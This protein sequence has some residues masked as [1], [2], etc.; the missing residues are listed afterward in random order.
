MNHELNMT[1]RSAKYGV[2]CALVAT[3]LTAVADA[4]LPKGWFRN[5]W[6]GYEP[7]A[8]METTDGPL[9]G[10]W[11]I[12]VSDIASQHGFGIL[13][14]RKYPAVEGDRL[15]VTFYGKGK[16]EAKISYVSFTAE[17]KWNQPR[18][19]RGFE[20]TDEWRLYE[21]EFVVSDKTS[22]EKTGFVQPS[23]HGTKDSECWFSDVRADVTRS[24]IDPVDFP[25]TRE[26]ADR[27]TAFKD[28]FE[29]GAKDGEI[30]T[31]DIAPGLLSKTQVGVYRTDGA[32]TLPYAAKASVP[33]ADDVALSVGSRLY[34]LKGVYTTHVRVGGRDLSLELK[35]VKPTK[36]IEGRLLDAGR[37]VGSFRMPRRVLPAD[38]RIDLNASGGWGVDVASLSD[39][40]LRHYLGRLNAAPTGPAAIAWEIVAEPGSN[41]G[42]AV[43]NLEV[44]SSRVIAKSSAVPYV[45]ERLATF[46]P[47]K[48]GWPL[49]FEDEFEGNEVDWS[50]WYFPHYAGQHKDCVHTDG[51]G[52]LVVEA[53]DDGTGKIVTDGIWSTTALEYGYF[54]ARLKFTK[55]PGWWAAFWLYGGINTNPFIDGFEIDIF[56]DYYT[57]PREGDSRFTG[58]LDHNNHVT[59]GANTKS[60]NFTTKVPG[61]F[62]DWH[63]IACKWTPFEIS[64]YMD[65]KLMGAKAGHG[66]YD[67]VTFDAIHHFAGITP[68]HAIC[69]GQV[70]RREKKN[71]ANFPERYLIDRV[72][73]YA[74]PQPKDEF[75]SVRWTRGPA[76]RAIVPEGSMLAFSVDA[77]AKQG[78]KVSGVYLFDNGYLIDYKAKPPYDFNV[79]FSGAAYE[80]TNYMKPGRSGVKPKF[81]GYTHVF[82]A[83]VQDESGRTSHTEPIWRIPAKVTE[84]PYEGAAQKIPGTLSP[85]R[86]DAGGRGVSVYTKDGVNKHWAPVRRGDT[87]TAAKSGYVGTL[88]GGDWL[89]YTVDVAEAGDYQVKA[90]VGTGVRQYAGLRL[91]LDGQTLGRLPLDSFNNWKRG[92]TDE[93]GE[94]TVRL[95][96]GRHV[97]T[98]GIEGGLTIHAIDFK[99]L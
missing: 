27:K 98:V 39:S 49:V 40:S 87:V 50:K 18:G 14:E 61:D 59:V 92:E 79:R 21:A 52:H 9:A 99:K 29:K 57:R 16:G 4:D 5:R 97:L 28:D 96:A 63:V 24:K 80:H 32:L 35:L 36:T 95:P 55:V 34:S 72:R 69:S 20:L 10:T 54:E 73:L 88:Y 11:A 68:L 60:W 31:T 64:Y 12:R 13:S 3:G 82:V 25:E 71:L 81:D 65:G 62:D 41:A 85:I 44:F 17:G 56:E 94:T 51:E 19:T 33:S 74:Y 48:A 45:I 22:K 53:K 75:P 38:F 84:A 78:R 46:D 47:V 6:N 2:L 91:F 90:T 67:S 7:H 86:F 70:Q 30:L 83:Y 8:K 23:L 1:V 77:V 26:L 43:D 58:L 93:C 37:D 76:E 42:V 66:A 15:R 89:N